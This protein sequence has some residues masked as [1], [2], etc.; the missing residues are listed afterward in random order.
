M[1]IFLDTLIFSLRVYKIFW[2]LSIC[3]K[4][5][6][7]FHKKEWKNVFAQDNF[8]CCFFKTSTICSF[9]LQVFVISQ[10]QVNSS[11]CS[12]FEVVRLLKQLMLALNTHP[13]GVKF[14]LIDWWVL[15][16]SRKITSFI[17][18]CMHQQN[19]LFDEDQHF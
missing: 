8:V 12:S 5:Y 16:S 17:I 1:D 2:E 10:Q 11:L 6:K 14:M 7:K 15:H 13:F 9:H 18:T 3:T 19:M 4:I